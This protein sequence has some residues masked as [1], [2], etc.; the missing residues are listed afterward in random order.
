MASVGRGFVLVSARASTVPRRTETCDACSWTEGP[1]PLTAQHEMCRPWQRKKNRDDI[2]G[3]SA[4]DQEAVQFRQQ[5]RQPQRLFGL[6]TLFPGY[7]CRVGAGGGGIQYRIYMMTMCCA[8]I[9]VRTAI[10][11]GDGVVAG[12]RGICMHASCGYD[13]IVDIEN[14]HVL[15][16][17]GLFVPKEHSYGWHARHSSRGWIIADAYADRRAIMNC[18]ASDRIQY[19]A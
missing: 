19:S 2:F 13:S 14:T 9:L 3:V 8:I 5:G 11:S 15:S 17:Y 4:G 16:I 12:K 7:L 10:A 1:S 18:C 6:L